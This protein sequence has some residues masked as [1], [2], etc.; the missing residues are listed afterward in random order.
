MQS[1]AHASTLYNSAVRRFVLALTFLVIY[2]PAVAEANGRFPKAQVI[3]TIPGDDGRTVFLR[4][5]FGILVSHDGGKTWRW[6]CEQAYGSQSTWDPPFAVTRDARVWIGMPNGMRVTKDGCDVT[7]VA[8]LDGETVVDFSDVPGEAGLYAATSTPN[9]PSFV[10]R[11][12][13]TGAWEK[14]GALPDLHVDTL[15]AAP[16]NAGRVYVTA[17]PNGT[18]K[19]RLFVSDDGGGTLTEVHTKLPVDGRVFLAAID[20][21]AQGRL[22]VRI[23][24]DAGSELA[25]ST[26][27]GA[28]FRVVLH[29]HGAMF[30]FARSEDGKT[31]WAGSG[32]PKEGIWRSVD[33][34]EHWESMAK[35]G[36]F[37]L[38]ADG[39]RLFACSNPYVP[40]GYAV[41]VS[42]DEGASFTPL[43]T[44]DSIEGPISCD[45][46]AGVACEAAWPAAR[47]LLATGGGE[48][49]TVPVASSQPSAGDAG[50]DAGTVT[51]GP[52]ARACGCA[53]P[54]N[55]TGGSPV[56][57]VV[58]AG[59]AWMERRRRK[60]DRMRPTRLESD[61]V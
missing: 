47:S 50:A 24:H 60:L 8:E 15:D 46:G 20:P 11:Q 43:A 18:R 26:D 32:D 3:E 14:R 36:V 44:F 2:A 21:K 41:A 38:H 34:G 29:M 40:N 48:G 25:V 16:S 54:G 23:L 28:T 5:T 10:W 52:Q 39:P 12:K 57:A 17:V 58:I 56:G 19:S 7:G 51:A 53:V 33:R 13:S 49:R 37:C 1:D 30:G 35:S 9:R 45:A 27:G 6:M 59:V 31:Y 55:R 4:A 42:L 22:L 61:S